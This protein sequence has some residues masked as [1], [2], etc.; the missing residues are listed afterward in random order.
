M[1][2]AIVFG[3]FVLGSLN[4]WSQ[5]SLWQLEIPQTDSTEKIIQHTAFSLVYA[6]QHEQAKWVAYEL[7]K[8]H[9]QK[10]YERSNHFYQDTL[11]ESGSADDKDYLS[12]GYDRGHLAPAADFSWS[13]TTMNESFLYSNMSPQVPAFNRGV[14]KRLEERVR[15]WARLYQKIYVVT[16]PVFTPNMPSIGPNKV[17]V[18]TS[19][20][21]VILDM[22]PKAPKAIGFLLLNESSQLELSS[23]ALSVDSIEQV[24][25][26]NFFWLLNDELEEKLESHLCISCWDFETVI[27]QEAIDEKLPSTPSVT[28][29]VQCKGI[30][31]T[32]NRCKNKTTSASG[33]CHLHEK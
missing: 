25:G 13:E 33:F 10:A 27:T 20:Y 32:G 15:N 3:L 21:K 17:S 6:E 4:S 7:T 8:E 30:T 5:S 22:N 28:S 31:Q 11:I 26:I 29:S 24:T 9:T 23:F 19:Y 2:K 18:P 1:L 16:G 12:S 14:W